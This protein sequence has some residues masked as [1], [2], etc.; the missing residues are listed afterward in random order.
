[1]KM[2]KEFLVV[3]LLLVSSQGLSATRPFQGEHKVVWLNEGAFAFESLPKGSTPLPGVPSG[4]T[5]DPNHRT[6]DCP[7]N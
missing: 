5:N 1:M 3:M 7:Q 6:G 4:C 2:M